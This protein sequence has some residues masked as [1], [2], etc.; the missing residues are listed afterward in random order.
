VI[1]LIGTDDTGDHRLDTTCSGRL[2]GENRYDRAHKFVA[3][4]DERYP[5]NRHWLIE[6]PGAG[7]DSSQ[8]FT[9]ETHPTAVGSLILFVD[10]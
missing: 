4:M 9:A 10:F 5:A 7:H 8:M 2:Q 1:V 6:V 3:Y